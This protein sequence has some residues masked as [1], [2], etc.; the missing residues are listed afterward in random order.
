MSKSTNKISTIGH[1]IKQRKVP[2][3]VFITPV[4]LAKKLIKR[5]SYKDTDIWLDPF[6]NDGSFYNNY[7]TDK[8]DWCEI[9]D[10]RDF[11]KY[12]KPVDI[13]SSNPPYS[14]LNDVL[15]HTLKICKKEFGYLLAI[16]NI[17]TAR[18]EKINR[19]GFYLKSMFMTKIY[20]WF[21]F[22]VYF[23]FSKEID[24]NLIDFDRK[25]WR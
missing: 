19:A 14:L 16:H 25:I 24:N 3:D 6:K 23:I 22:S 7:P 18:M 5:H 15:D 1:K 8:K 11:F 13:I 17:T 21:G 12:E 9:L 4:E 10:N 2:R 20:K